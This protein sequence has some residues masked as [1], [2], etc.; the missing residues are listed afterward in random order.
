M[1]DNNRTRG[2]THKKTKNIITHITFQSKQLKPKNPSATRIRVINSYN[3]IFS[4]VPNGGADRVIT[5]CGISFRKLNLRRVQVFFYFFLENGK[6]LRKTITLRLH[7]KMRSPP[8][9]LPAAEQPARRLRGHTK[10]KRRCNIQI[11]TRV[12]EEGRGQGS[13]ECV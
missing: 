6:P 3:V 2:D 8:P 11:D 1:V 13:L 5:Y 10:W 4:Y 9:R 12:T 7:N